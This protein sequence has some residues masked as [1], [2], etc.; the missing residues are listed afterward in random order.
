MRTKAIT[1]LADVI[2][3]AQ[4]QDR[5]PAG[6]AFAIESAGMLQSPETAA[7]LEHLRNQVDELAATSWR[8][9]TA[10]RRART[11]AL[12]TGGAA[13]R[14]AAR[15]AE[16]QTAL[17]DSLVGV[18]GAQ[19]ERNELE[20][21]NLEAA[22]RAQKVINELR[23]RVAELEAAADESRPV[24]EDPIAYELTPAALVEDPRP[25]LVKLKAPETVA[26]LRWLLGGGPR[27]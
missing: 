26:R 8:Y 10:W 5:T 4:Q 17:Q 12:S 23:A 27:G 24:D 6:I 9:R 21:A 7:E 14:Y 15:A 20:K 1:A 19:L 11:R 16:L 2:C 3:R 22:E 13:D 25:A 18:L